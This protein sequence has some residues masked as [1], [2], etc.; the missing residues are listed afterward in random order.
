MNPY[1]M[2]T[3][4]WCGVI[5]IIVIL[6]VDTFIIHP[7]VKD[8]SGIT[9]DE[10]LNEVCY[11]EKSIKYPT[12]SNTTINRLCYLEEVGRKLSE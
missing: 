10:A 2:L 12:A 8:I 6:F 5:S 9:K 11:L 1:V 3:L 7:P 4:F